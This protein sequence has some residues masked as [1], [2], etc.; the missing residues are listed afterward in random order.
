MD[1]E[2]IG[3]DEETGIA[4]Y[5]EWEDESYDPWDPRDN[6]N[7]TKLC[8][9]HRRYDFPNELDAEPETPDK[10]QLEA[11]GVLGIWTVYAYEHGAITVRLGNGGNPYTCPWDSG[12]LG[13]IAIT[14]ESW[15]LVQGNT[16]YTDELGEAMA[17]AEI[18]EYDA[19][20]NGYYKRIVVEQDGEY[21]DGCGGYSCPRLDDK[22]VTEDAEAWHLD[23]VRREKTKRADRETRALLGDWGALADTIGSYAADRRRMAD[24]TA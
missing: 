16:P 8:L 4:T 15:E 12:A 6:D 10:E 13:F 20:L 5:V 2:E 19:Y 21:V 11:W 14:K 17:E 9:F 1:R 24:A 18:D 23:A 7:G 22:Y 3:H